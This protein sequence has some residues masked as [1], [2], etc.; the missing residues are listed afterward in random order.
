MIVQP[1]DRMARRMTAKA[2]SEREDHPADKGCIFVGNDVHRI[3]ED[4]WHMVNREEAMGNIDVCG[5]LSFVRMIGRSRLD[6]V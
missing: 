3:F 2:S 6:P 4:L 5:D 1:V